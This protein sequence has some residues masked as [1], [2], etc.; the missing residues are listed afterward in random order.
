ML[1]VLLNDRNYCEHML[2]THSSLIKVPVM[3]PDTCC[4]IYIK[5]ICC[6]WFERFG[7]LYFM[8]C[9]NQ[10]WWGMRI[11]T[12]HVHAL[13]STNM[14]F[15]YIARLLLRSISQVTLL[16]HTCKCQ[17]KIELHCISYEKEKTIIHFLIFILKLKPL[18][19]LHSS[20]LLIV[21]ISLLFLIIFI[22]TWHVYK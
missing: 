17:V 7:H 21:E 3:G 14:I 22:V 12:I 11:Q 8:Y 5:N 2:C 15:V 10:W 13:Y 1:H 6:S 4:C 16:A 20:V 18:G 9:R 19:K